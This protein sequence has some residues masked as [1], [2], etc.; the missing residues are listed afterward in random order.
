MK[1]GLLRHPVARLVAATAVVGSLADWVLFATLVV[2]VDQLVGGGTWATAIV[3]LVRIVPGV[4]LAPLAARQVE[5]RSERGV[6]RVD[7][8]GSLLRH[9]VVR[10]VA[11]VA[12]AGAFAIRF[13]PAIL[14][15]LLVLEFAA[16]MQAAARESI[17]SRHVP[18][19]HFT[20]LN[21]LTAVAGYGLLPVGP[22]VV[23]ATGPGWG[24]VLAVGAYV[25]LVATYLVALR[26]ALARG[27]G[28]DGLVRNPRMRGEVATSEVLGS[29]TTDV[30]EGSDGAAW[31]RVTVAAALGVL[32]AVALFTLGP[33]FAGAWQGDRTA[34]GWLYAAVLAGGAIGFILANRRRFRA[35]LAMLVAAAGLAVAMLGWWAPGL[36]LLGVGAGGAYLDLQTRL[37]HAASD[38]SQ[39]AA[40]FAILKVTTAGA[41]AGA[42]VLAGMASLD[43]VL[44]AGAVAAVAGAA[45]AA[46]GTGRLLRL[47]MRALVEVALRLV[48]RVEVAHADRRV[49]G[50]AVVVSNHPHWLDGAVALL[51]DRTLRPIA[52]RQRHRGARVAIWAAD[53]VLTGEGAGSAFT[54]AAAHL[55]AG[56]RVW[57][58]PEGGAHTDRTLRRPRS[59]AVRMA[60]LA[61][62]P[63]QPL[64]IAWAD[65]HTGPDLHQWR[66]WRRRVVRVTWGEPVPTSGTVELDN[67]RM[68]AALAEVA[69]LVPP[70]T[71][72]VTPAA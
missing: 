49:A 59:G 3:L 63:V 37:Q 50:P 51:T 62:V 54:G 12:L 15:A 55:R 26:P 1:P 41:V 57:L 16:A 6:E 18:R 27:R 40:A 13:V 64:G 68:M 56:G 28:A 32:P 33:S 24:W 58:A 60:H 25:V 31:R 10:V 47:G 42:P 8:A 17:I 21:T 66:P 5:R 69:D 35:D 34:T 9:E 53:A 48:V 70:R 11:V 65:D 22:L 14:L 20:R 52:R 39:F 71:T 19:A 43:A 23:A 30:E 46:S 45:V 29:P 4:L 2:T 36:A 61:G 38:P 72:S 7:L 44:V 67:A